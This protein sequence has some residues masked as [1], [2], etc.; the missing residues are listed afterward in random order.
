MGKTVLTDD[1]I[2]NLLV[3]GWNFSRKVIRGKY[4]YIHRRRGQKSKNICK[5]KGNEELW[6]RIE[7][8][9]KVD[10]TREKSKKRR[11]PKSKIDSIRTN[12]V[13]QMAHDRGR[14]KHKSCVYRLNGY[15][16]LWEY[17]LEPTYAANLTIFNEENVEPVKQIE[18]NG[19]IIW[20]VYASP[21]FCA[22]CSRYMQKEGEEIQDNYLTINTAIPL[23]PVL[24]KVRVKNDQ[25]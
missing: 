23:V 11:R 4:E 10:E 13:E 16:T 17:S 24:L 5:Y 6:S 21:I 2:R 25:P 8:I 18:S 15:C 3:E 22:G 1:E 9:K 12:L 14:P 20:R 7:E 19:K